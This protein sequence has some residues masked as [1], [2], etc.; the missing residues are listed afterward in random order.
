MSAP[1]RNHASEIDGHVRRETADQLH[2][3]LL[4]VT[5]GLP[6]T[7]PLDAGMLRRSIE[8]CSGWRLDE[9][10]SCTAMAK[11]LHWFPESSCSTY[12]DGDNWDYL[13]CGECGQKRGGSI[14]VECDAC[15][16]ERETHEG[17][18]AIERW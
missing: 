7:G 5:A 11:V 8:L 1:A 16:P 6:A 2:L 17:V 10:D 4:R 13:P 9:C 12:A 3:E 15:A 18:E 14:R